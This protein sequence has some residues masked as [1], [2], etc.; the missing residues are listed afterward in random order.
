MRSYLELEQFVVSEQ[1][2]RLEQARRDALLREA[3]AGGSRRALRHAQGE[4]TLRPGPLSLLGRGVELLGVVF[5]VVLGAVAELLHR[6][7]DVPVAPRVTRNGVEDA[8]A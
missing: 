8:V 3:R 4:R 6:V 1:A 5:G 2:A 7:R